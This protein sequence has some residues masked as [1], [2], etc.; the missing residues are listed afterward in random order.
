MLI[1]FRFNSFFDVIGISPSI[2]IERTMD[3]ARQI[4]QWTPHTGVKADLYPPHLDLSPDGPDYL[5]V[6]KIFNGMRLL[7][8]GFVLASIIPESIKDFVYSDPDNGATMAK[9]DERNKTLREQ[10]KNILKEPNVGDCVKTPWYTDESFGQQQ[11]TG[12]NPVTIE[13][14]STR[15]AKEFGE[16][17]RKQGK[18]KIADAIA[19]AAKSKS[20]FV[21]DCSYYRSA[22]GAGPLDVLSAGIK[23]PD[24]ARFAC[25]SV[26]LFILIKGKL[27]P[28]AIVIDY[29]QDMAHS[30]CLFN[31]RLHPVENANK[32]DIAEQATDWPWRYAKTC[33]SSA[34]WIRHEVKV[35]LN[36]CHFVEEATIVA[37]HRAFPVEHPVYQ[38]LQPHWL[39]TLPLNAG[40][41]TTLVPHVVIPLIGLTDVATYKFIKD[42]YNRFDW[43][44]HYVPNHL[45]S[46]G[47]PLDEINGDKFHNYAYGKEILLMW[48]LLHT[49][50][51]AFLK[52]SGITEE[53][54]AKDDAIDY[55][56]KEMQSDQGGQ[57]P[58]FPTIKTLAQLVDCVTMCIH[59]ASPQHTAVNYTQEYYN[60]YVPNK[61]PAICAPLPQTHQEL[62]T[63]GEKEL[64]KA[65]PVGRANEWL[66]ASHLV[67]LL[68]YQVADDQNIFNYGVSLYKLTEDDPKQEALHDAAR[69]FVED[70]L[71]FDG[72]MEATEKKLDN[73]EIPYHV[74]Q[75]K[76]NAVSILI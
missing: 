4:Y 45:A 73:Q 51:E 54:V 62:E 17:A 3:D 56:C 40:A 8:V 46:R 15:W 35:H 74:L 47:F 20:L 55:W 16:E 70:L 48:N 30:V 37:A 59:I 10:K 27:H 60:S 5:N 1:S 23:D 2:P 52:A 33:A 7:D 76:L 18:G 12:A 29:K 24:H 63:Y 61:P 58:S 43:Q 31:R 57:M 53:S 69:K 42:A 6:F 66:L 36:D 67:H 64:M 68:S 65:L 26:S 39:K 71:E 34:D 22:I 50:V 38:C 75:P 13:A 19:S 41:R 49:F 14:A 25:A 72:V 32:D 11:F 21:Q 28:T 44:G 9:L